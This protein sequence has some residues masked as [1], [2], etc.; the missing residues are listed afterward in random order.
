MMSGMVAAISGETCAEVLPAILE[1]AAVAAPRHF[2]D[3]Y[4]ESAVRGSYGACLLATGMLG[5]ASPARQEAAPPPQA[6]AALRTPESRDRI[7][8]LQ[9][10]ASPIRSLDP[11]DEDFGDLAPIGRA[12]GQARIVFLGEAA[13]G[14]GG[15]FLGK[16]RLVKYLHQKLGF[17]VLVFESPQY[18]GAKVWDALR[19]GGDPVAA[20]RRGVLPAWSMAREIQPLAEYLA[21]QANGPR[22]LFYAGYDPKLGPP[23]SLVTRSAELRAVLDTLGMLDGFTTDSIVWRGLSWSLATKDSLASDSVAVED[24]ARGM[25]RLG[26]ALAARSTEPA[27]RV[28][29]QLLASAASNARQ[30]RQTRIALAAND[31]WSWTGSNLREEQGARNI[32]WLAND[33][34]PGHRLIVW[35]ATIHAARSVS[36]VETGDSTKSYADSRPTGH[37]VSLALGS[38]MYTIGFVALSGEV[39]LGNESWK[40]TPDQKPAAELEELLGA[41]GFQ[42]AFLDYRRIARGG[43]WLRQPMFSRPF[44]EQSMRARWTEVLDGIV[45]L[46]EM[47]P[48]TWPSFEPKRTP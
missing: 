8:W 35:S 34:F 31:T 42:T 39:R 21:S 41:A 2:P 18:E 4:K 33:R 43:D 25:A 7:A 20:L 17:D 45:F 22:P 5:C 9:R 30:Q 38:G 40:I 46:R 14:E 47:A 11:G 27:S 6:N 1:R 15:T 10:H 24:F 3:R 48:A 29:Q 32:L 36:G 28:W 19:S 26:A 44:A 12:I 23:T 37:H 16:T 13:H